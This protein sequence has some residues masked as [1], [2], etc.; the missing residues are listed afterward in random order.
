MFKFLINLGMI[1]NCGHSFS[2]RIADKEFYFDGD[3][4]DNVVSINDRKVDRKLFNDTYEWSK[5]YNQDYETEDKEPTTI[6]E[7][8][9]REIISESIQK[10]LKEM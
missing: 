10:V 1:G 2:V 8:R 5:V 7:A 6:S 9:L 4:A 3:G